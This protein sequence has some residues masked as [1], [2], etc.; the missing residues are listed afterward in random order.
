[1]S[2]YISLTG[3]KNAQT[4]LSVVANNMILAGL[5]TTVDS[6]RSEL[7]LLGCEPSSVQRLSRG[8]Q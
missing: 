1:M 4:G 3:L 2:F 5:I 7:L 6:R 8:A